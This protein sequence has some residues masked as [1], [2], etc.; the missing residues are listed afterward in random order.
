M[1]TTTTFEYKGRTLKIVPSDG[2]AEEG[3]RNA[4]LYDAFIGGDSWPFESI[5][6]E[7]NAIA[8]AKQ[9]IDVR[10]EEL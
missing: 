6:G 2:F 9:L 1:R 4:D 10:A 5:Q 3:Q 7:G 8:A